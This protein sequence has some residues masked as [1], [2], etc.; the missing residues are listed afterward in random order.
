MRALALIFVVCCKASAL[1]STEEGLVIGIAVSGAVALV[2]IT[3]AICIYVR[4]WRRSVAWSTAD[5]SDDKYTVAT[6]V[7]A[8]ENRSV[9]DYLSSHEYQRSFLIGRGSSAAVY[10]TIVGDGSFVALKHIET[11]SLTAQE[12]HAILRELRILSKLR[13]PNIVQYH[14]VEEKSN[15]K[16]VLLFMEYLHHS[17]GS[18]VRKNGAPLNEGIVQR[19]VRQLL[20]GLSYLHGKGVVH[21]DIKAD[22]VLL[23]A[24]KG[25]VKL[26]DFGS[27]KALHQRRSM[28]LL[29]RHT[30]HHSSEQNTLVGTA[31]WMAPELINPTSDSD[32]VY[33]YKID[34]WS[35]G[36][37]VCE[38]INEG[39]TPWPPFD[40]D[41]EALLYIGTLQ[42]PPVIESPGRSVECI[43]FIKKCLTR[44]P[45]LRP[46][47]AELLQHRWL[48]CSPAEDVAQPLSGNVSVQESA[49][50]VPNIASSRSNGPP[51][52]VRFAYT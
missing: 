45:A 22:N 34:I 31:L 44:D 15:T 9:E 33:D 41:W 36:V 48:M 24:T 23:N 12:S 32:Q 46:S 3:L 5:A 27:A 47:A 21:R 25:V 35:V 11:A 19:Y 8:V 10:A 30:T 52:E 28:T 1:T 26:A 39:N 38:L 14:H 50:E 37:T 2:A 40:S 13:H 6:G 16:E 51:R 17:L 7:R 18:L 43:K 29:T 20:E 49:E 42:E 4:Y